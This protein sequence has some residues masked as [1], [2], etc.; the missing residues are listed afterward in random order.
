MKKR[1]L[2][3]L[4]VF[5]IIDAGPADTPMPY[6]C[7]CSSDVYNCSEFYSQKAAQKCF[8]YCYESVGDVHKLDRDSDLKACES[9]P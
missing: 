3:L 9:L 4:V 6:S 7:D 1:V 8:D 2:I 5:R